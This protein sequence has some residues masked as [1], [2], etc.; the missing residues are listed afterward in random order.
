[1]FFFV[2]LNLCN[3]KRLILHKNVYTT[4]HAE[5]IPYLTEND[6]L[7]FLKKRRNLQSQSDI[8]YEFQRG[9]CTS[10]SIKNQALSCGESKLFLLSIKANVI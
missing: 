1:M 2:L 9:L 8:L 3:F 4:H 10:E 6:H 5:K 7:L